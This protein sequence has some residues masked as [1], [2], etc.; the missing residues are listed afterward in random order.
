MR[1]ARR[2]TSPA[3]AGSRRPARSRRRRRGRSARGHAAAPE[4]QVGVGVFGGDGAEH[5]VRRQPG[6]VGG[7][8]GP[9]P[10]AGAS[11][12]A[13][14]GIGHQVPNLAHAGTRAPR[15]QSAAAICLRPCALTSPRRTV[16]AGPP[17]VHAV[18]ADR[19]LTRGQ[20]RSA[21]V[22]SHRADLQPLP[23]VGR[24][25]PGRGGA[26]SHRAPDCLR[27]VGPADLGLLDG[28]L[29]GER[30]ALRGLLALLQDPGLDPVQRGDQ[31][32]SPCL[33]QPPR[34]LPAVS[35]GRTVS[36]T[37]PYVGPASSARTMRN[38][39]AP[40]TSSPAQSARCTGAAPRQAGSSEKCR[41]TQP[42]GG[43][44][45]ALCGSRAP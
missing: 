16:R 45:R 12:A 37:T 9:L 20:R 10:A 4:Q 24:P 34:Q 15:A 33:G 26:G 29:R 2:R 32:R 8:A 6:D 41:F 40:V 7:V 1:R 27:R 21:G 36:V 22:G 23:R 43:M 14:A 5:L 31:Q 35:V 28:H 19:E 17:D 30:D 38:V 3:G 13:G 25:R 42:C 44:S 39:V 11:R 18:L